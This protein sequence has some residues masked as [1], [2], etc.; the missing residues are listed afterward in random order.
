MIRKV[1]VSDGSIVVE[2]DL[3]EHREVERH[4]INPC[5]FGENF[6]AWVK[7]EILRSGD[8]GMQLSEPI[9]ADYG[10]GF[11]ATHGKDR[12]RIAFSYVGDVP[13]D[14][15][16]LWFVTVKNDPGR[17]LAKRLFHKPDQQALRQLRY[18]VRQILASNDA[19]K[20]VSA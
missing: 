6:A 17:N 14:P 11:C 16:A 1:G 13:Q 3:F 2:T 7:R 9:R 5:C 15:P 8:L 20:I 18:R 10:W 12:F 19:I 4:F